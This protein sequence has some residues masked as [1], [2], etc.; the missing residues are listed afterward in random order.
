MSKLYSTIT[1]ELIDTDLEAKI[2]EEPTV[3]Q[4]TVEVPS[5]LYTA[6]ETSTNEEEVE[7]IVDDEKKTYSYSAPNRLYTQ[8]IPEKPAI[9]ANEHIF[10]YVPKVTRNTAGIAKYVLEQFNIVDGQVSLRDDY[11]TQKIMSSLLQLEIIM[12]VTELPDIGVPNKLYIVP[13]TTTLSDGYIWN[14]TLSMWTSLGTMELSLTNYYTKAEVD[15]M[16]PTMI[17]L[18][19]YYT[20]LEINTIVVSLQE[21]ISNRY[22]KAEVD[23]LLPVAVDL[24]AYYTKTETDAM[25]NV[26]AQQIQDI[27]NGQLELKVYDTIEEADD[28]NLPNG[29]IAFVVSKIITI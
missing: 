10:V 24:S 22:T 1:T 14:T 15:A 17:D 29:S 2:V 19:D 26:I 18:S 4:P 20:K 21:Q 23:A 11:L 7:A 28:Q 13:I 12:V 25:I 3:A 6:I 5:K 8:L 16:M 27:L 9:L